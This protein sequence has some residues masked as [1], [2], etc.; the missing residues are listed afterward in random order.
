[1]THGH[2]DAMPW[3]VDDAVDKPHDTETAARLQL[4]LFDRPACRQTGGRSRIERPTRGSRAFGASRGIVKLGKARRAARA[5]SIER[6][7]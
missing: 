2:D 4:D 7:G 1:V 6:D 3:E 5:P